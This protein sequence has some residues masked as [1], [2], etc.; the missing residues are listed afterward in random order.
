MRRNAEKVSSLT[1]YNANKI[2]CSQNSHIRPNECFQLMFSLALS[3]ML[4]LSFTLGVEVKVSSVDK[5]YKMD[6]FKVNNAILK[7]KQTVL[8]NHSLMI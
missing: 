4:E 2:K 1:L 8:S 6:L 3:L 5:D 7:M